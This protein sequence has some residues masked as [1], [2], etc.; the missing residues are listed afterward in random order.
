MTAR[1]RRSLRGTQDERFG[2][3][4]DRDWCRVRLVATRQFRIGPLRVPL[5]QCG[6]NKTRW[7]RMIWWYVQDPARFHREQALV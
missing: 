4:A 2:C 5:A 6:T 7:L 3:A 1:W